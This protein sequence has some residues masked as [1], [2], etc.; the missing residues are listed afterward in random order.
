M[1]NDDY[2]PNCVRIKKAKTAGIEKGNDTERVWEVTITTQTV[3]ALKKQ[4]PQVAACG[5][6]Y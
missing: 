6:C 4:K 1:G 5:S 2:H 3:H